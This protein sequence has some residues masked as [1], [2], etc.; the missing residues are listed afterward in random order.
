MDVLA[1]NFHGGTE[2]SQNPVRVADL[3]PRF[4]PRLF[5]IGIT[6]AN[7]LSA[8]SSWNPMKI[9]FELQGDVGAILEWKLK[10]IDFGKGN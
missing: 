10:E 6:A 1:Q 8:A 3:R 5:R 7:H 2:K 4:E 9:S